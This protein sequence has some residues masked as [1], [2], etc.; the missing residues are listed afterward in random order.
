MR[1]AIAR[2][3]SLIGFALAAVLLVIAGGAACDRLAELR[4]AHRWVAHTLT[5]QAN[6]AQV[7]SLLSDA[8]T[9]QRGFLLTGQSPYLEPYDAARTRL[10]QELEQLRRLTRDNP[11]QQERIAALEKLSQQKLA[12]LSA[13][14]TAR[15]SSSRRSRA[16]RARR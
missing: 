8:E 5:I 11:S 1:Q 2:R 7:L 10:P 12:E 16:H 14:I 15:E 6:L 9:G 4:Q 13:T 3:L